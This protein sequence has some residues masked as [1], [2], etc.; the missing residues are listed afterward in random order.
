[1]KRLIF[2][3]YLGLMIGCVGGEEMPSGDGI[4]TLDHDLSV[5]DQGDEVRAV[6]QYLTT[7]GYFA[8][9]DLA[10]RYPAWRPAIDRV[11]ID[12]A[13]FDLTTADAI[14]ALQTKF[15][16]PVTGVVDSAT[17]ELMKL[18][19]C[20][21]PE[22]MAPVDSADKFAWWVGRWS[23]S[24]LTWRLASTPGGIPLSTA[25]FEAGQAFS[26]WSAQTNL[27]FT[28]VT[29]T[30]NID[31]VWAN[32]APG[33]AL[34]SSSAPDP[35]GARIEL[36]ASEPWST[37]SRTPAGQI[38]FQT[39]LI[40][41]IGHALG[42][43]HSAFTSP[44]PVMFEAYTGNRR[45]L[46]VDDKVAISTLYD[47]TTSLVGGIAATDIAVGA[48]GTTWITGTN[49][50]GGGYQVYQYTG[51]SFAPTDGGGVRVA[52][53]P[54]GKPWVITSEGLIFRR[55][56]NTASSGSWEQ[57]GGQ[58]ASDIAVGGNGAVW[59]TTKTPL[60]GGFQVAKFNG[61]G[62]DL[63]D[64]GAV[65]LAVGPTGVP[66][67]VTSAGIVFRRTSS[68]ATS[69][70]WEQLPFGEGPVFDIGIG[71]GNYAWTTR[72][73]DTPVGKFLSVA[74]WNEQAATSDQAPV[75]KWLSWLAMSSGTTPNSSISVGPNGNPFFL[76]TTGAIRT[77]S[78]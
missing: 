35:N 10:R 73:I 25:Q 75:K 29:G 18:P 64:G 4:Q 9:A 56:T 15:N 61:S 36:D 60:G 62:W 1:M 11:P 20:G 49:P 67:V 74:V 70:S 24:N 57:I 26:K 69:G 19:R 6:H 33:G 14:R 45:T 50:L 47:V 21:V 8:N 52:V 34:A 27:T 41:E 51:N 71:P 39:V 5:G 66:W 72:N 54:D 63:T 12:L 44:Q 55:T 23:P 31:I 37:L 42:L 59:I 48:N 76:T 32:G 46:D 65:R 77:S 16:L 53:A 28:Q 7:Y 78:R 30:P 13:T 17:R 58:L 2:A 3:G 43:N 22:G 68:S 38:D 40:H